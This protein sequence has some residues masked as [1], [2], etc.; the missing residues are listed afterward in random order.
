MASSP[1]QDPVG[2]YDEAQEADAPRQGTT[3]P[4]AGVLTRFSHSMLGE[5]PS[6]SASIK[7]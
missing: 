7:G 1:T 6:A 4:Y 3:I 5:L 2:A